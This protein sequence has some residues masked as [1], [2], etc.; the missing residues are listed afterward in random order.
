MA[1]VDWPE[2]A[3]I[4]AM[5]FVVGAVFVLL[6]LEA[7]LRSVIYYGGDDAS[8]FDLLLPRGLRLGL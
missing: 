2:W 7:R 5:I 1:R 6:T 8:R 4:A 3:G